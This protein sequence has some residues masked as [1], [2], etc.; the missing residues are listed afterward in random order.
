[1]STSLA[2]AQEVVKSTIHSGSTRLTNKVRQTVGQPIAPKAQTALVYGFQAPILMKVEVDA[3]VDVAVYPNPVSEILFVEAPKPD[4][5]FSIF[6]PQGKLV[7]QG[8]LQEK[9]Q[10][11][12]L[13][14]LPVGVFLLRIYNAKGVE[15]VVA[16]IIKEY[17]LTLTTPAPKTTIEN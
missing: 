5:S 4:Y 15:K 13:H 12:L 6:T 8:I 10:P 14:H 9:K 2:F 1:M 3:A 16:K 7:S 17:D 11:I